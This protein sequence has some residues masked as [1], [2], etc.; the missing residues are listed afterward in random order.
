MVRSGFR[1]EREGDAQ[2]NERCQPRPNHQVWYCTEQVFRWDFQEESCPEQEFKRDD[3]SIDFGRDDMI[4]IQDDDESGD[5]DTDRHPSLSQQHLESN[6]C[7][8]LRSTSALS[9]A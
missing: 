2:G 6:A 3:V 4:K 1:W 5:Q 9:S 8:G 7:T